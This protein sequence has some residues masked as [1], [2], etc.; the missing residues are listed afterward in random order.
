M[1]DVSPIVPEARQI[2]VD[3]GRVY[4]EHTRPWFIGLLVH[5][6]ALKGGFI[7]GCS[8]IDF[9]LFLD[10][11]AFGADG[12]LPLDVGMALHR[13]LARIDPAP[14][15]Y[16]QCY[17]FPPRLLPQGQK[18]SMGPISGAYHLLLGELPVPE[19]TSEQVRERARRTL[20]E[21][22]PDPRDVANNLLEHG[23]G[24]LAR[25]VRLLCT[26]VGPTLFS[27]LAYQAQDPLAVWR[28]SKVEA[29]VR[30]AATEPVLAREVQRFYEQVRTYYE[31]DASVAAALGVLEQGIHFLTLAQKWYAPRLG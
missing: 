17:A 29:I 7:P 3:A 5:G 13:Q 4:V 25:L 31:V 9:Q 6:S 16:L 20:S 19:A 28:L 10:E 11:A 14:F 23:G 21:L 1:F 24:R 18:G 2:V 8:D 12:T 26:D 30:L 15:Q 22:R 27:L